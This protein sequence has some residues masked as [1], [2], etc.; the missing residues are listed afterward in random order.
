MLIREVR[1]EHVCIEQSKIK[2]SEITRGQEILEK[3]IG[4]FFYF[5][6]E[7]CLNTWPKQCL[8]IR[9]RVPR[10]EPAYRAQ[11]PFAVHEINKIYI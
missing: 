6:N 1:P 11:S 5:E 7:K 9:A 8:L 4:T 3:I 2:T 10:T